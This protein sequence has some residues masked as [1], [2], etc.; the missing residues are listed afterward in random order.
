MSS[1]YSGNN[2]I[3]TA[4]AGPQDNPPLPSGHPET[5]GEEA[6]QEQYLCTSEAG[7]GGGSLQTALLDLR[8]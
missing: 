3:A 6:A 2:V 7:G 5:Q 8:T 1:N 4:L